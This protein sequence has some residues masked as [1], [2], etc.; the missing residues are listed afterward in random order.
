MSHHI[1]DISF[2]YWNSAV[3]RASVKLGIFDILEKQ[4]INLDELSQSLGSNQRFTE[5]FLASCVALNLL[6]KDDEVYQ[7]TEETSEFLV[8]GKAKYIGDHILHITNSW[9]T[10]GNLD[11]LVREGRTELPFENGFVDANTY[12]TEY[13]N[14]QHARAIAGQ[15]DHL[16]HSVDLSNKHKLLD[17]GGGAGSYSIALCAANPELKVVLVEQKEPL[18]IARPLITENGLQDRIQ[19]LEG[20]FN[21]I[22][23]ESD[24]DV[25]LISGVVC[26]KSAAECRSLFRRA[27]NALLPNG[28]VIVQDFM[29]ISRDAQQQFLDTMMDLYLKIAFDPGASD[30]QGDEVQSWLDEVGFINPQQVA[31]PTQYALIMASKP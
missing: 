9:Y 24:Y 16:V 21:T 30:R 20:D 3:L 1:Y 29:Q 26:T 31:M 18:E 17:L 4:P 10:W 8:S 15:S 13:M 22:T 28:L 23:L 5:A 6:Q 7:N 11:Q 12:W 27:Y 25:V 2:N 14:G 19:L